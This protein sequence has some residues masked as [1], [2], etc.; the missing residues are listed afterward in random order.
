MKDY[1]D[2]RYNLDN[3][4]TLYAYNPYWMVDN[5]YSEY[6]GDRVYGRLEVSY[7]ILKNLKVLGRIGGDFDNFKYGTSQARLDFSEGSYQAMGNGTTTPEPGYYSNYGNNKSQIDA[8]IL[9]MGN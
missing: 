7:D 3:Y 2:V 9:V 8:S 5:N 4:F 1:N 6:S